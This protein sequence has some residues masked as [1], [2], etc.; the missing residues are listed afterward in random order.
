VGNRIEYYRR[1]S[2]R[3]TQD[4]GFSDE[5]LDALGLFGLLALCALS[6][7]AVAEPERATGLD[8]DGMNRRSG[9]RT[10]CSGAMN[11]KWLDQT[12]IPPDKADTASST[13]CAINPTTRVRGLI[14]ELAAGT[15]ARTRS[16]AKWQHCIARFWTWKRSNRLGTAPVD[17]W[18]R[19]IDQAP[20]RAAVAQWM[21]KAQGL[22]RAPFGTSD[23]R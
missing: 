19:Q 11:G 7:V 9:R 14:E 13:S 5:G 20:D 22:F 12:A 18:L 6:S 10:I 16:P 1:R 8:A 17:A 15:P 4:G 21:G 23:R 3:Q 2:H